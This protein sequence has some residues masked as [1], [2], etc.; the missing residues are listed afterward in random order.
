MIGSKHMYTGTEI[1]N[2]WSQATGGQVKMVGC[3]ENSLTML[4][5]YLAEVTG[6]GKDWGRALRLMYEVQ[7]ELLGREPEVYPAWVKEE[8]ESWKEGSIFP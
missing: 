1:A 8:G 7:L 2:L 5:E 3:D 4:E 6:R